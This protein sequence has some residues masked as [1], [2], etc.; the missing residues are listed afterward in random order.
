M[1]TKAS[2]IFFLF[3]F[4]SQKIHSQNCNFICNADFD[5]IQFPSA[6]AFPDSTQMP[7]WKTTA[8][9]NQFEV[10]LN[11]YNGVP[12]YSGTQFLELNAY[13]YSTI[14]QS[15]YAAP[16]MALN[17]SFA[18]RGRTG[19]DSMSV[20]IADSSGNEIILGT[21][22]DGDTAW[23]Y[24]SLNYVIPS[25]SGSNFTI[26]FN[27]IYV[28]GNN[29]QI[30]NFLDAVSMCQ[31]N[32]GL[33]ETNFLNSLQMF[34]NP[35]TETLNIQLTNKNLNYQLKVYNLLSQLVFIQ[36]LNESTSIDIKNLSEG[37]YL[38]EVTTT[39]YPRTDTAIKRGKF[40]KL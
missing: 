21:F 1:K 26:K 16:G 29:P 31:T 32:V 25:T 20:S 39:D 2:L 34:P 30:G 40:L 5:S 38:Y 13:F 10:W 11:G 24:Y 9:D 15:F 6:P 28:T 8:N 7:C 14:Y 23:G 27:S 33:Q 36:N 3:F 22:G 12:A 19:V 4:L 18:H 35:A 17:I 37:T